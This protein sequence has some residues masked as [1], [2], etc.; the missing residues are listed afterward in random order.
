MK[1]LLVCVVG[2]LLAGC[3]GGGGDGGSVPATPGAATSGSATIP[4]T[5]VQRS[6]VQQALTSTNQS[7]QLAQ[8]GSG[9][10]TLAHVR[11]ALAGERATDATCS[12]GQTFT[13]VQI[14]TN[15]DSV[16]LNAYYDLNCTKLWYSAQGTLT[17]T[18]STAGTLRINY[19]YYTVAG[20]IYEY[21]ADTLTLSG[22]GTGSGFFS[23]QAAI[24][25]K[26]NSAPYMNLGLGCS[27]GATSDTCSGAEAD[28]LAGLGI[29]QAAA[30]TVSAGLTSSGGN[31]VASVNGSASANTGTLNSTSVVA[32]GPFT[33][34]I[35]GGTQLDAATV[36]GSLTFTSAGLIVAGGLTVTDSADGATVSIAYNGTTQ[37]LS[38]SLTQTATGTAVAS[39]SVNVNGTGT[40]SY[41]GGATG[42]ITNW[43]V[44]S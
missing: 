34:G 23:L 43:V 32:T 37:T 9:S 12:N 6:L 1:Y 8:Y 33:F 20:S 19:T 26:A 36:G 44:Q 18:S 4:T 5:T 15:V 17:A 27:I 2:L 24:S 16:A 7:S 21:A 39:F 11:R 42:T 31:F 30:I 10:S 38:G 35:M 28:H 29:D 13:L 41:S 14:A 3:G 22:I 25:N 40:V